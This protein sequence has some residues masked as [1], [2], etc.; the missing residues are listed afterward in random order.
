MKHGFLIHPEPVP[1]M[2]KAALPQTPLG[3]LALLLVVACWQGC[4]S[5]PRVAPEWVPGTYDFVVRTYADDL[6][7]LS[8]TL[9]VDAEGPRSVKTDK[10]RCLRSSRPRAPS[11][12]LHVT[13]D[14]SLDVTIDIVTSD[15]R[16]I[17]GLLY[18]GQG[19]SP[20]EG[21]PLQ[22]VP[23]GGRGT[24]GGA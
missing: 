1:G 7:L 3:R 10:V 17:S 13:F 20:G 12:R 22:W 14:C 19:I 5:V 18:W 8:G 4:A 2:T 11:T 15:R 6:G 21:R 24:P 16:P 9:E 23:K